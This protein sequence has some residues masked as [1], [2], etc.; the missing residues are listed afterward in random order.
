MYF[1]TLGQGA[2]FWDSLE[3]FGTVGIFPYQISNN[4]LLGT[5]DPCDPSLGSFED[6]SPAHVS[7]R[8]QFRRFL[9]SFLCCFVFSKWNIHF[10]ILVFS[11]PIPFCLFL[12]LYNVLL[13]ILLLCLSL[14]ILNFLFRLL[15]LSLS[16]FY[17][18][19]CCLLSFSSDFLYLSSSTFS[20][21]CLCVLLLLLLL[22]FCSFL[23]FQLFNF[24]LPFLLIFWH[25]SFSFVFLILFF[26]FYSLWWSC[27]TPG[28]FLKFSF[29]FIFSIDLCYLFPFSP[30][31][32]SLLTVNFLSFSHS[33]T[34]CVVSSSYKQNLVNLN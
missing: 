24:C 16:V 14:N 23:H 21:P 33:S 20:F 32:F 27:P 12:F 4:L 26:F 18:L 25:F 8:P 1:G 22:L 9:P 6:I 29:L 17:F 7:C 2:W 11:D 10:F 19:S 3:K 34:C 13:S 30:L 31:L 15:S 28:L 5:C